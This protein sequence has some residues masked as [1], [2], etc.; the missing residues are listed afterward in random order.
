MAKI[1][2]TDTV[3]V[4]AVDTVTSTQAS[5]KRYIEEHINYPEVEKEAQISGHVYASFIVE[6]DGSVTN[7]KILHGVA[8]GRA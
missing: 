8:G 5:L 7:T 4:W 3:H 2:G 6:K 1:Y